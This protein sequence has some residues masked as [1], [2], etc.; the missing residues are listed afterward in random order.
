MLDVLNQLAPVG[1]AIGAMLGGAAT[2]V[3]ALYRGRAHLLRAKRGDPELPLPP[4]MLPRL[5]RR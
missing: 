2:L 5:P 1:V 4:P 3:T